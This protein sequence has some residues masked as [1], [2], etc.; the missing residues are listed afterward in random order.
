MF[1]VDSQS[2]HTFDF[3]APN[4]L[5]LYADDLVMRVASQLVLHIHE[6]VSREPGKPMYVYDLPEQ[7]HWPD[8]C[9]IAEAHLRE[10]CGATGSHYDEKDHKIVVCVEGGI[11]IDVRERITR[12]TPLYDGVPQP[13]AS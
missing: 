4:R 7:F 2:L 9:R 5:G 3:S 10:Q 13:A 1:S 12:Q 6:F 8:A 11:I